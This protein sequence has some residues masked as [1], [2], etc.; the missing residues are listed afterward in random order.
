MLR[1]FGAGC[2]AEERNVE[3]RGLAQFDSFNN[4]EQQ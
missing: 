1:W 3:N 4:T 2:Q